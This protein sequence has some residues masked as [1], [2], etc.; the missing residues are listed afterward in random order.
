[1]DVSI[2]SFDVKMDVKNKGIELE[3]SE[4]ND[5]NRLGDLI[6]TKAHLIWCK[7][8]THRAH[9]K[10]I[11]WTEFVEMVNDTAQ[12]PVKKAVSKKT[13]SKKASAKAATPVAGSDT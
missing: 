9:G 1:M 6:I 2:K 12:K 5:G 11:K 7:G 3:I 10:K 8:K 4:P 13:A